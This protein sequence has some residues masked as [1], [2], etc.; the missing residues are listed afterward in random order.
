MFSLMMG[1]TDALVRMAGYP[2]A[3]EV[4]VCRMRRSRNNMGDL[5]PW[6]ISRAKPGWDAAV[7]SCAPHRGDVDG[8][9]ASAACFKFG[10]AMW[11]APAWCL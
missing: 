4:R 1:A 3:R 6:G 9:V 2:C 10:G 7:A 11:H 8:C 5:H